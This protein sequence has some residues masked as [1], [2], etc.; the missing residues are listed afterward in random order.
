LT[1]TTTV[2]S[3]GNTQTVA[4]STFLNDAAAF[5]GGADAAKQTVIW[6][7]L[8]GGTTNA[9]GVFTT[10]GGANNGYNAILDGVATNQVLVN[11]RPGIAVKNSGTITIAGDSNNPNGIDLSGS[12]YVGSVLNNG[13]THSLAGHFGQYDEPIV[14]AI[15]AGEN[16]NFGSYGISGGLGA[17]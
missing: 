15:R 16:L 10:T 8:N 17:D 5:M 3:D 1:P 14:L 2:P 13:D 4:F 7:A 6:T 12:N 9:T 11:I